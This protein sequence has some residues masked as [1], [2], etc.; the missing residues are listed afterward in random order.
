M[1]RP[2]EERT[3]TTHDGLELFY[4][5]WPAREEPKGAVLLLHRGHEHGGRMVHLADELDLPDHGI[6]AWDARG[7][8]RS[9]GPRGDA[10]GF[11]ALVR[12]LDDFVAHIGQTDGIPTSD[13]AIVAQSV[14]AVVAAAWVHDIAPTIRG[15]VL[16]SP[17]F[18]VRLYVPLARPGLAVLR[19]L[20]GPFTVPSYVRPDMLTHDNERSSTYDSDP[21][22]TKPISVDLLLALAH[23]GDRLVADAKAITTPTMLLVSGSDA[24]VSQRAQ[25]DFF[26][27]LG[28][29]T[30]ERHVLPG[31]FHDT[32]G[33]R[34]RAPVVQQVRTWLLDRFAAPAETHSWLDA[35]RRSYTRDEA[36]A[37]ATP[38]P[39][40]SLMGAWWALN[41]AVLRVGSLLSEGLATGIRTGF[42]SGESLDYVYRDEAQG[43]GPIG[44][45][46][47]RVYLEQVGW[48]GIR[49]RKELVEE[50]IA[51]GLTRL[52]AS[53]TETVILDVAAGHGRYVLDALSRGAFPD[54]V[55]LRDADLGNVQ[56]GRGLITAR[57][58]K[59][60]VRFEVGDAFDADSVAAVEPR[61]TLGVVS[62]LYELF[63]D[64]DEV[65]R[66]LE[67]LARAIPPGGYLVTTCQ[68]WHPQLELIARALTSHRGGRAWVM[69][70]RTQAEMDQLVAAAGFTKV[71]QRVE[72]AGLFTV[73][74]ARRDG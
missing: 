63:G 59:G 28:S 32:L 7:N 17:A 64:N 50:L 31:F 57:G 9:E 67:G 25:H 27:N 38:L 46:I 18:E 44:R 53:G 45:L 47:D 24:V 73:S 54:R 5:C 60:I 42:D 58:L 37:L 74:L 68:P 22:I 66:S 69:R 20:F 16:A 29:A 23:A 40:T 51:E 21:L 39:W 26:V 30:K 36:E 1:S 72:E 70:R 62:G 14:G 8:G 10:P 61:P 56:A 48:R 41:R 52:K 55:V 71:A 3:F 11:A 65:A 15:M 12:D 43:F 33:E 13:V 35:H 34:D 2:V 49:Q 6:Y 19:T 4:R